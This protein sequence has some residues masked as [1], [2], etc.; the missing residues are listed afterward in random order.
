MRLRLVREPF[1]H[2]DYIFELKHDGFRAVV[3]LQAREC[4]V[5]SRN[6][7]NLGFEALKR[8]LTK[9]PVENA[10]IDGEVI[11]V[12]AK[13]ASQFNHLLSR[14]GEPVFYAFDLLWLDG[15]DLRQMPLVERKKRLARLV[16][17]AK[18]PRLLYAQHVIQQG[19][20]F[21]AEICTR[22]L[23]GIVAK[24]KLGIYKDDAPGWLKLK[25]PTY[26][27]AEGR[28]ELLTRGR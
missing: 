24:R 1:D 7:R 11:C 9:L 12:D 26:S 23:E 3:Y 25:N 10:I 28:H 16:R 5:I 20:A 14:K 13:G 19:R 8:S 21:F 17:A 27:Q 18:C 2:P 15:E 4:K 22:D 6:Q